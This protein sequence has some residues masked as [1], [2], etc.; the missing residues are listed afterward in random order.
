MSLT[1]LLSYSEDYLDNYNKV[2]SEFISQLLRGDKLAF[3]NDQISK[4]TL[5]YYD[6]LKMDNLIEQVK[7]D[8]KVK[9]YMHDKFA[10][11]KRPSR[12][13]F[14]NVVGTI[15]PGYFKKVIEA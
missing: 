3:K 2:D 11:T 4:V 6:E 12:Q 8:E 15:Y 1:N 9:Q 10:T 5:P 13:F 14:L 7:D